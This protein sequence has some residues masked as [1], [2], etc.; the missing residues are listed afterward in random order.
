MSESD[1]SNGYSVLDGEGA[2]LQCIPTGADLDE[3]EHDPKEEDPNLE[4]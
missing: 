2:V 4:E 3:D 1:S